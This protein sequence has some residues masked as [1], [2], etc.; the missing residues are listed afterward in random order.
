MTIE[1]L[2][3]DIKW[4]F[5]KIKYKYKSLSDN[6]RYLICVILIFA[7]IVVAFCINRHLI[8]PK[9]DYPTIL[10]QSIS[11]KYNKNGVG[12]EIDIVLAGDIMCHDGQLLDAKVEDTNG[13]QSYDFDGCF[14]DISQ[15]ISSADLAAANFEGV[16][17]SN[18]TG[19]KGYPEF[20]IPKE[21]VTSLKTVGFDAF[22]TANAQYNNSGLDG[23]TYTSKELN[24]NGI[25]SFGTSAN[26][27]EPVI[28][29][30]SGMKIA[31]ISMVTPDY[32]NNIENQYFSK[33][34]IN[35]Y[36]KNK[37]KED[38]DYC[39]KHKADFII[40]YM[41]WGTGEE[42]TPT[43]QMT[44]IA[45]YMISLG[46]DV[47]IGGGSH[48][49]M[50]MEQITVDDYYDV[51]KQ[52]LG[53]VAYSLGNFISNQRD[54]SHDIGCLLNLKIRKTNYDTT[55]VTGVSYLP[56]YTNVDIDNG[57]NFKVV[58][59]TSSVAP[60]WMDDYNKERYQSAKSIV[61]TIM[62][63]RLALSDY[64]ISKY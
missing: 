19:A 40:V 46:I 29:E 10:A 32:I 59:V 37:I 30:R 4:I 55:Y 3:K 38:I 17:A 52:N 15:F 8:S 22:A 36:S 18:V 43:E 49:V 61:E 9:T 14:K 6:T 64:F 31:F 63:Y 20:F 21:F 41:R 11:T 53:Y 35:I 58:P 33:E 62:E 47:I 34:N 44:S 60:D 45:K 24:N 54:D 57:K 23:I 7:L 50:P 1:K 26:K 5:L 12:N 39:K 28:L 48:V 13:E 16:V 42:T 56:I 2:L 25:S 51:S 27:M